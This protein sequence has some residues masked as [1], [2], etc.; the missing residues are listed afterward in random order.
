VECVRAAYPTQIRKHPAVNQGLENQK[1]AKFTALD[2]RSA[3]Y[4]QGV[5][6]V[7]CAA[8]DAVKLIDVDSTDGCYG[9]E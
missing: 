9:R 5:V 8:S 4:A 6:G 1:A 2:V 3:R 7:V